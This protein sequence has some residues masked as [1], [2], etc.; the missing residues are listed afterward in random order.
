[1]EAFRRVG[2]A[3]ARRF[4]YARYFLT[5]R[6]TSLANLDRLQGCRVLVLCYG[7]IYRSPFVGQRLRD[8]LSDSGWEIR[9]AGFHHKEGRSCE[10][11]FVARAAKLGTDLGSHRSRLVTEGDMAWADLIVIMDGQNRLLL[12]DM[13]K[14]VGRKV[15]WLGTLLQDA[16][17]DVTDPYGLD[18]ELVDGTVA[19]LVQCTDSLVDELRRVSA[20]TIGASRESTV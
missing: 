20:S 11:S 3:I 4:R 17:P 6:K 13:S 16:R 15:V 1:M 9:T 19:R 5:A 14:E 18:D 2:R 7:N 12:H 8:L 10:K